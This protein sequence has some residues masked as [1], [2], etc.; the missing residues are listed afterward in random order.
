MA[1]AVFILALGF[2]RVKFPAVCYGVLPNSINAL[3]GLE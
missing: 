3:A 1:G 2:A